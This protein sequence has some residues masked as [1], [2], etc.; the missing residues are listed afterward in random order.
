MEENKMNKPLLAF[1]IV[2]LIISVRV[3]YNLKFGEK[4]L[5]VQQNKDESEMPDNDNSSTI[6]GKQ[7]RVS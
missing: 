4:K 3:L 1:G 7:Y 2:G 5:T 6:Q